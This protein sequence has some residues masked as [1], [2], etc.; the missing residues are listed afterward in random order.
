M[1][2]L[3]EE[4]V[5]EWLNRQ[6]F[7]TIRGIKLGVQ[8]MDILAIKLHANSVECRHVEVQASVHPVSYIAK[9]PKEVQ[10]STGRSSGSAKHRTMDELEHSVKEW[11][12]HKYHMKMKDKL[13][14]SLVDARWS[15]ELVVHHVKHPD[16]LDAIKRHGVRVY[17]LSQI[18][19]DLRTNAKKQPIRAAG[20]ADFVDLV[21]LE[22][23]K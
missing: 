6:G 11:I 4:L 8:E 12:E 10:K 3:A 14:I 1:A 15:F 20:G 16:E 2:L 22:D 7:F 18:V 13:R 5:E 9:V 17:L 21:L 23:N 19:N